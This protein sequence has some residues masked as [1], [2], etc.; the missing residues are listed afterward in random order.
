MTTQRIIERAHAAGFVEVAP[1][2]VNTIEL[3]PEVRDMCAAN[4]CH[5]YN[6]CWT[7]PPGCGSLAECRARI[8]DYSVGVLVQTVGQLEDSW[9]FEGM[10]DTEEAHKTKFN[11][12]IAQLDSEKLRMLPIGAG[13]CTRCKECT[14]PDKPCRFP[15]AAISSMEAY[16]MLVNQVVTANGLKYNHGPNTVCYSSCILFNKED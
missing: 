10:K 11:T 16:G 5:Q 13:A 14:Y 15:G 3:M 8:A 1:L 2:D 12:L 7:C 4:T 9:D 6:K